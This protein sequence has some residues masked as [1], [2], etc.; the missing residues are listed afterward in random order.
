[1]KRINGLGSGLERM[2]K[3]IV[4]RMKKRTARWPWWAWWIIGVGAH[5]CLMVCGLLVYAVFM[6]VF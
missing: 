4:E 2:M 1:M 6:E 5:L 3:R